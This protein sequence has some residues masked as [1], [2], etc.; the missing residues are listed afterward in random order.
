LDKSNIPVA[1]LGLQPTE[2]LKRD[3]LAGPYH[4]AFHQLVQSAIF[5][6]MATALL[7]TSQKN[8]QALFFCHP[9]EVTNLRGQRNENI[10]KLK[11]H[12]NLREIFIE[13]RQELTRS[14]LGLQTQE[15][16]VSIHRKSLGP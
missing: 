1:R 8:D 14:Y 7:Q 6:D 10:S 12:F 9:K 5:F 2:E 15:G 13:E 16:E 4:P 11:K 3:F